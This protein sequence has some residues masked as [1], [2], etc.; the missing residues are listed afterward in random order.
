M[1]ISSRLL[2]LFVFYCLVGQYGKLFD[3]R[4]FHPFKKSNKTYNKMN[5]CSL[6]ITGLPII[7]LSVNSC[8]SSPFGSCLDMVLV[9]FSPERCG[10][11]VWAI[12][13]VVKGA[14]Y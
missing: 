7:I 11:K 13:R 10:N 12:I 14:T 9:V 2:S 3:I 6:K 1:S 8:F 4:L 5:F